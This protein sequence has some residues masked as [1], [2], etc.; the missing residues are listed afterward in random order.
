MRHFTVEEANEALGDVQPLAEGIVRE[1]RRLRRV[2]DQLERVAA[3]VAGNG[4]GHDVRRITALHAAEE[5]ASGKLAAS[6]QRLQALG[7]QVKDLET[8]LVDFP[9]YHPDSG[10]TVLLCWHVGEEEIG[11]W[12]GLEEGFAGRKPLPF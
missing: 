12:H 6:L 2:R 5:D 8:G 1:F 7:V 4:G 9:A 11:F 10:E 3:T